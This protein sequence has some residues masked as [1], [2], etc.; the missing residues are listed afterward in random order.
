MKKGKI[1]FVMAA[2]LCA[3]VS[4]MQKDTAPEDIVVPVF[5]DV[6]YDFGSF[7]DRGYVVLSAT[8][9]ADNGV[10]EAGF[11][12]GRNEATLSYAQTDIIDL[13]LS[14]MLDSIEYDTEYCFYARAS[15]DVN[16]IRTKMIRLRTPKRL[17]DFKPT[18][19][20]NPEDPDDPDNPDNPDNPEEP[21]EPGTPDEP[22]VPDN[23]P[24]TPPEGTGITISND[25][26]REYMLG[27]CDK[28][29]DGIIVMDEAATVEEINICTDE[30]ETLD[31]IQY[32]TS[33]RSIVADGSVW[34]GALTSVA[35]EHNT[36]LEKFSCRHNYL[37]SF[38]FPPSLV[39]LDVRYNNLTNPDF[40]GLSKLK[41]L[42]CFG[43]YM[44]K[45]DLK[46]MPRLEELVCGM[47]SFTELDVSNNLNLKLLD[48][49][50]SPMLETVYLARGQ[51]IE[52]IIASN[53]IKITYKQ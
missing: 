38:L 7:L 40:K 5:M 25:N 34:S 33:L 48:L 3:S 6:S 23:P 50:D 10:S 9:N 15:N 17:E 28:N 39:E 36:K 49:S 27:L 30:I 26:F 47:N 16:E 20:D 8:L 11:M 12:V 31:G 18:E 52:T 46:P 22:D 42:D 24:L 14:L 43:N 45:L 35:L 21:E 1:I 53:K 41:R 29:H 51:K 37:N 2:V 13:T 19:P 32:F 4:C 44:K